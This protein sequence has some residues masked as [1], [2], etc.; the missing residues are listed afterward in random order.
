MMVLTMTMRHPVL[1]ALS[2]C[3]AAVYS[4]M[5]GGR[6]TL[7]FQLIICLPVL[8]LSTII[9][10]LVNQRGVTPLLYVNSQP[11]TLESVI[12]GLT[13]G[14]MFASILLWFS[15]YNKVMTSDKF[16]F[17]FGGALPSITLLF[18]IALRFVPRFTAQAGAV[19]DAKRGIG[20]HIDEGGVMRRIRSGGSMLTA[21][22]TWSL[23]NAVITADSMNA[24]GYGAARRTRFTI[25]RLTRRDA[26]A[27]VLLAALFV[28]SAAGGFMGF[29]KALYYPRIDISGI[30]ARSL[31]WYIGYGVL[32]FFPVFYGVWFRVRVFFV[33]KHSAGI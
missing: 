20:C 28:F 11:V 15:C 16:L 9:N 14:M 27:M 26:I 5:L 8:L 33:L 18:S 7:R 19:A 13:S 21:L 22:T 17:I 12:F 2:L 30:Y 25:Y 31:F 29:G 32:C 10:P 4:I 24:R 23:E 1:L 6:R 3:A